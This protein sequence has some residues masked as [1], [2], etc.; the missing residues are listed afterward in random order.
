MGNADSKQARKESESILI[1]DLVSKRSKDSLYTDFTSYDAHDVHEDTPTDRLAQSENREAEKAS[2]R[3]GSSSHGSNNTRDDELVSLPNQ[4]IPVSKRISDDQIHV[5]MAMADLMA[6][7]QVVANNSNNLPLT[8][9][10]DP[11]L[12]R[13]V[14][15]LSSEDYARK[16]AAFIPADVR[17]I[18]GMFTRYGR[19]WDLPTSD[20]S[21]VWQMIARYYKPHTCKLDSWFLWTIS[22]ISHIYQQEYNACDGAQEPGRS[23]GGACCNTLLKVLYDSAIEADGTA[24]NEGTARSLFEDDEDD[25]EESTVMGKSFRSMYSIDY[26]HM[27]HNIISW[28]RI[29][30]QMKSEFKDI[31][32]SQY[33]KITT[34]R[35]LDLSK[36]FSFQPENFD[37]HRNKKRSLLI[38]CNYIDSNGAELKASHDDI[39]SIKVSYVATCSIFGGGF[40]TQ[41]AI[42]MKWPL[43]FA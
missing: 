24:H 15:T 5:N 12:D 16:S 17:V 4:M 1:T 23:Y 42:I 27:N 14:S 19:V 28:A 39:R 22:N 36:P 2:G 34:T 30:T 10:D 6:Y 40:C 18:G 33:P 13:T 11:E 43:S 25:E 9:R 8:R 35:K 41:I 3:N 29:L 32:Y 37:S 31:G 20:V 21:S 38:G 7:L 26:S